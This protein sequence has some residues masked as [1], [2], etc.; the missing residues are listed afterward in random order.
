MHHHWFFFSHV[1]RKG[2]RT[3]T[4]TIF[5]RDLSCGRTLRT[6]GY[7]GRK[8]CPKT[9]VSSLSVSSIIG[10]LEHRGVFL[11]FV[12][13][14]LIAVSRTPSLPA[15]VANSNLCSGHLRSISAALLLLRSA[16]RVGHVLLASKGK[17]QHKALKT[18]TETGHNWRI[19]KWLLQTYLCPVKKTS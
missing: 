18:D 4:K 8:P 9:H 10:S 14:L 12:Q 11:G 19:V 16:L 5:S 2:D 17:I 7:R 13:T 1:D 3:G 15:V 6:V